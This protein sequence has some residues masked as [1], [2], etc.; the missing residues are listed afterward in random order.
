MAENELVLIVYWC[1]AKL[2]EVVISGEHED[3]KWVDAEEALNFVEHPGVKGDIEA[4]LKEKN[5]K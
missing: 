5:S 1:K 2:R 4:F 3:Y